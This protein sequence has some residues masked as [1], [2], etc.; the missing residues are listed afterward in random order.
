[1]LPEEAKQLVFTQMLK[2]GLYDEGWTFGWDTA[3]RRLGMCCYKRK[4]I[5]LSV[6]YV[7]LNDRAV[8]LDTILHEIAHALVGWGHKHG[9]VWQAK[10]VAVGAKPVACK[11]A[12]DVVSAPA[13]IEAKCPACP[14]VYKRY[15]APPRGRKYW[16]R[17]CGPAA[18]LLT[19]KRT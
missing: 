8:V 1:M 12:A 6:D 10:A 15:K 4:R 3:K 11:T 5:S 16:C 2:H 17:K 19:W 14:M 7:R 13:P 18:G 9:P